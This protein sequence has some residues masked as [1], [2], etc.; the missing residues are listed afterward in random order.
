MPRDGIQNLLR[1]RLNPCQ[2]LF[3]VHIVIFGEDEGKSYLLFCVE[4]ET[5]ERD[6]RRAEGDEFPLLFVCVILRQCAAC[7]HDRISC[8]PPL[9]SELRL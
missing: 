9:C 6:I 3:C 4:S 5:R 2:R 8:I 1:N 7:V